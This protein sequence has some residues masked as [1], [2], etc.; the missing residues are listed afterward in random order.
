MPFKI[1]NTSI[2]DPNEVKSIFSLQT[3]LDDCHHNLKKY[4]LDQVFTMVQPAEGGLNPN[5]E[6]CGEIDT[7]GTDLFKHHRNPS[8]QAA[9]DSS[10]WCATFSNKNAL[11][12]EDQSLLLHRFH[13]NV[14]P[15]LHHRVVNDMSAFD[16]MAHGGL[17]FLKL[18][19]D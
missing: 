19:L 16:S 7:V 3:Q 13:K 15:N 14:S 1:V 18:L 11:F 4:L 5:H 17:L 12:Q 6:K 8:P 2:N 9:A 10:Q